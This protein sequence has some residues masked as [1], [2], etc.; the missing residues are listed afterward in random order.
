MRELEARVGTGARTSPDLIA[1]RELERYY[2]ALDAEL[3]AVNLTERE[4]LLLCDLLNG[5]VIS[6]DLPDVPE[7]SSPAAIRYELY[8]A[9]RLDRIDGKW[10]VDGAGL[11]R[12][13]EGWSYTQSLAVRDAV[14]RW[15]LIQEGRDATECLVE[16]GLIRPAVMKLIPPG[17]AAG[18]SDGGG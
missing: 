2:L 11:L 14:T 3:R 1:R 5:S 10:N 17:P 9:I 12:R 13:V 6:A 7:V 15:W 8:D 16:V 4:A 18:G